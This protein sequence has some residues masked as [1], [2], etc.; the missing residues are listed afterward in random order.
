MVQGAGTYSGLAV[1]LAV[2]L[3]CSRETPPKLEASTQ[4]VAK[5]L[6]YSVVWGDTPLGVRSYWLEFSRGQLRI[7]GEAN[8]A[9]FLAS[10]QL[11][12][13]HQQEEARQILKVCPDANAEPSDDEATAEDA[14]RDDNHSQITV[15][16]AEA[17]RLDASGR[18]SIS[19]PP[20]V[21][22]ATS[23]GNRVGLRASA[24]PYLFVESSSDAI[25]CRA[26]HGSGQSSLETFDL[27]NQKFLTLPTKAELAELGALARHSQRVSLLECLA[28]RVGPD[29][30]KLGSE[31]LLELE[32]WSAVPILA[33][34]GKLSF[35][36]TLG[37]MRSHVEG[38][39]RC[40][41]IVEG[42]SALLSRFAPPRGL[43]AFRKLQPKAELRGW[44][45][46]APN[47]LAR[48]ATIDRAFADH[49]RGVEK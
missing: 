30:R 19:E 25:Y 42:S 40:P 39:I 44:S 2:S 14:A 6:E 26:A 12:R 16:G 8:G 10:G 3:G 13:W 38:V 29:G 49:A 32:P 36:V 4:P 27:A 47:E 24:G 15:F 34:S 17:E 11:Y 1:L 20:S 18:V 22:D 5:S 9:L 35:E 33:P 43:D 31:E 37:M 41:V 28:P 46:L 48:L 45:S 21:E 7:A 23:F